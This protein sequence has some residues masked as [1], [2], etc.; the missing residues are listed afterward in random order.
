MKYIL[1]LLI[2]TGC[3]KDKY[4]S[5]FYTAQDKNNS[6]MKAIKKN[7][8]DEVNL[9]IEQCSYL[10]NTTSIFGILATALEENQIEIF[11]YL[12]SSRYT[13][14]TNN[15]D[16]FSF[17]NYAIEE[18]QL[19]V[20]QYAIE[21]GFPVNYT[22]SYYGRSLL[23][24][25]ANK[26]K[27]DIIDYLVSQ[28]ADLNIFTCNDVTGWQATPLNFTVYSDQANTAKH[29]IENYSN[30][31]TNLSYTIQSMLYNALERPSINIMKYLVNDYKIPLEP[32]YMFTAIDSLDTNFLQFLYDNGLTNINITNHA[33]HNLIQALDYSI[34][35]GLMSDYTT[36]MVQATKNWIRNKLWS[37]D[38][39][40]FPKDTIEQFDLLTIA[41]KNHHLETVKFGI[42]QGFPID[43]TE[44]TNGYSLLHVTATEGNSEIFDY[45]MSKGANIN[46]TSK[47]GFIAPIY[48]IKS[49]YNK[50]IA[51]IID[52]YSN[53]I[54]NTPSF[55]DQLFCHSLYQ[56]ISGIWFDLLHNQNYKLTDEQLF[57]V[58]LTMNTN[59]IDYLFNQGLSNIYI[60]NNQGQNPLQYLQSQIDQSIISNYSTDKLN[61]TKHWYKMKEW[62]Y[63]TEYSSSK[64][65]NKQFQLLKK[66]VKDNQINIIKYGSSQYFG[67]NTREYNTFDDSEGPSLLHYAAFEGNKEI[68]DY[69]M[70]NGGDLNLITGD[71]ATGLFNVP[72]YAVLGDKV[73]M[74]NY[75]LSKY[76]D[77]ITNYIEGQSL[78][79]TI[80]LESI[81]NYSSNI[82]SY[83]INEVKYSVDDS[84]LFFGTMYM[85]TN[86]LEYL[87]NIGITNFNVLNKDGLTP[88]E[89]IESSDSKEIRKRYSD[90]QVNGVKTWLKQKSVLKTK[91]S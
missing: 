6:L 26:G 18:N 62:D 39:S 79:D 56:G 14:F 40:K 83:L 15:D 7:N 1:C 49:N 19:E 36:E 45:L 16:L 42:E 11:E 35:N 60:K 55:Y 2:L 20:I 28:K 86:S 34:N 4:S 37:F 8:L 75:I 31:I 21:K 9:A 25:A 64:N 90:E 13:S 91:N 22:E 78:T 44:S 57:P 81:R 85:N 51:A 84:S 77:K 89:W 48:A 12:L 59:T 23:H 68:F 67:A 43:F 66:A 41:I 72:L 29:I 87:Y 38:L 24:I 80:Y 70:W 52:K 65:L 10:T 46:L 63:Q 69:L 58:L 54:T 53:Q 76:S 30:Q 71:E 3:T 47:E 27:N 5:S 74:L 33:G 82:L 73:E 17:L 32:S 88:L 61:E 50:F